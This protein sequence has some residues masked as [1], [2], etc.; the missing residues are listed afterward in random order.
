MEGIVNKQCTTGYILGN[1]S[2][3][4]LQ[5]K[6]KVIEDPEWVLVVVCYFK[7]STRGLL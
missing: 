6:V 7:E 5:I 2:A 3:I 1:N 4:I